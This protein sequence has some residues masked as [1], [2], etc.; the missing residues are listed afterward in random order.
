MKVNL[1][2]TARCSL[3]FAGMLSAGPCIHGAA[4]QEITWFMPLWK[5][6]DLLEQ[7]YAKPVTCEDPRRLSRSEVEF[8]GSGN[9]SL[10]VLQHSLVMPPGANPAETPALG[11]ELV[12][13]IVDAYHRQNPGQARFRVLESKW[14]VHIVPSQVHNEDGVLAAAS[15]PLDTVVSVPKARRTPSEHLTAL[16]Q[17]VSAASGIPVVASTSWFDNYYAANGYLLPAMVTAA[18]RPYM[19]LEWGVNNMPARDALI[20]LLQGSSTTM[21][22]RMNCGVKAWGDNA[23]YFGM[24]PLQVGPSRVVVAHD[25]CTNCQ[26]IPVSKNTP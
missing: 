4:A 15:S 19:L 8:L 25:R 9:Q 17:A 20:D 3:V 11:A 2:K 5:A 7:L 12:N 13:R 21:S 14:G 16:F 6:A 24:H 18:E 23:C 1:W 22:W 26:R 10:R